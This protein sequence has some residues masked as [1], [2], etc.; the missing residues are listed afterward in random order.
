[1][2]S[3]VINEE[4]YLRRVAKVISNVHR[5]TGRLKQSVAESSFDAWTR[6]YK[7]DENAPNALV[8]YYT[9]GSLVAMGLDLAIREASQNTRS[10]DD[11]MRL[12]WERHGRD[13]YQ[14]NPQGIDESSM[15]DLIREATGFN[16]SD[17][18]ARY[19]YGREDVP[20]GELLKSQGI[21]LSWAPAK[22][23]LGLGARI[24]SVQGQCTIA[25]VYEGEAA[26][27]AG[28]SAGD[29]LVAIEGLR[30]TDE[31]SLRSLL[32]RWQAGDEVTIHVF[33]RDEL[34]DFR[35][36]I[37]EPAAT[38]CSLQRSAAVD[39]QLH[40]SSSD[41]KTVNKAGSIGEQAGNA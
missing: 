6:F 22:T 19:A 1:V 7:Q 5:G 27:R 10:L 29:T 4:A 18:L 3:G 17:F 33:R 35:L 38:E 14:G 16:A 36:V 26:H 23:D 11:V 8:S 32:S 31:K 12:M 40:G 2:R 37:A 30:V 28:L 25:S 20:L 13:F 21:T 34:R 41:D 15:P 9:K 24:R 39:S